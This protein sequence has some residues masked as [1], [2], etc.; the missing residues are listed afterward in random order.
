LGIL[1]ITADS[2]GAV[3][4][5]TYN[6]AAV[7]SGE[8]WKM[9]NVRNSDLPTETVTCVVVDNTDV[10]W[11]GTDKAGIVKFTGTRK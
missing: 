1:D 11:F 9:F 7:F 3:W 10:K 8:K 6:G 5:G 4:A 2:N